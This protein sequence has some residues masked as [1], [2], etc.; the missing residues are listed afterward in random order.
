[1][2]EK[3][4]FSVCILI[5]EAAAREQILTFVCFMN[6]HIHVNNAHSNLPEQLGSHSNELL[7][8]K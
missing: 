1:M 3:T 5:F 8:C 7:F 6:K 4:H 2:E